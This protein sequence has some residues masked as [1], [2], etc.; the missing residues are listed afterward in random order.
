MQISNSE[1]KEKYI[2]RCLELALNGIPSAFPNPL[3]G[4]VIVHNDKIIGEGFHTEYG[5]AHAEVNA[6]NS[7]KNKDLLPNSTIYVSLEPCSHFGKTPPCTDLILQNKI[8]NVVIA[9]KDPNP[10]TSGIGIRKMLENGISV[11]VGILEKEAAELNKRFFTFHQ[12]KRPY[13]ILKWAQ[14]MDGFIDKHNKKPENITTEHSK[15]LLHKW[16]TEEQ[17]I[18]VGTNTILKDNPEL[19]ARKWKGQNPIRIVIDRE[20]CF[21][22]TTLNIFNNKA[23]T[24]VFN[25][26]DEKIVENIEFIQIDFSQ[27]VILQILEKLYQRQIQS[28]IVEGGA[29]LLQSFININIW[30]EARVFIATDKFF[31]NG[32]EANKLPKAPIKKEY[33]ESD[34]LYFYRNY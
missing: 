32:V 31:V 16:R 6:I 14:T 8:K 34:L 7:V 28:L 29:K 30:D 19:T 23:K 5:K 27:N 11:T 3:V 2:S 12:K 15:I 18:I 10:I 33:V 26:I 4:A 13:I 25:S 17:A 21:N 22:R 1:N 24:M 20:L 9:S